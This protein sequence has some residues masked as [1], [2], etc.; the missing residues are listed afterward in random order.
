MRGELAGTAREVAG[1]ARE[2]AASAGDWVPIF[3]RAGADGEMNGEMN[4]EATAETVEAP[5]VKPATPAR[6]RAASSAPIDE[7]EQAG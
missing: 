2:A 6:K 7:A 3:Q 4:G 5:E 1:R